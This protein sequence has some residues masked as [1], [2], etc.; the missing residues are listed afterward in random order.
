MNT[1][2][3]PKHA[4]DLTLTHNSPRGTYETVAQDDAYCRERGRPIRWVSEE[5]RAKAIETNEM[6]EAQW[7][8]I[9][10]GSFYRLAACDLDVL[11]AAACVGGE[12][13]WFP[14][15]EAK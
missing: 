10:P 9:S 13:V 5:Q 12:T 6:W 2:T 1:L 7:Y 14:I 3:L 15:P 4:C 11:L 8:P